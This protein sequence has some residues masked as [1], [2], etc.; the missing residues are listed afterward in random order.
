MDQIWC[1]RSTIG[2]ILVEHFELLQH[3]FS[4]NEQYFPLTTNQ[5]KHQHK[6]NFCFKPCCCSCWNTNILLR[7]SYKRDSIGCTPYISKMQSQCPLHSQVSSLC[8]MTFSIW[9]HADA[10][11]MVTNFHL[12][13]IFCSILQSP[14]SSS[15]SGKQIQLLDQYIQSGYLVTSIQQVEVSKVLF[16]IGDRDIFQIISRFDFFCSFILLCI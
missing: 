3:Y 5:H 13:N 9:W 2:K 14:A 8:D 10:S 6:Q 16:L 1:H 12:A 4:A 15:V 11:L 7:F